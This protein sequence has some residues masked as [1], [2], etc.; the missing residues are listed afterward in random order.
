MEKETINITR[1][2]LDDFMRQIEGIKSTIEILQNKELMK[3]IEE[4]EELKKRGVKLFK[5]NV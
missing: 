5:I 2:E 4:S 3:Q 1:E